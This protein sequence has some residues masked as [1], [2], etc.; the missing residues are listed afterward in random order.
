MIKFR[1]TA[2]RNWSTTNTLRTS[3][4][5]MN[6]M[7]RD[8]ASQHNWYRGGMR[9]INLPSILWILSK[10][11]FENVVKC[12]SITFAIYYLLNQYETLGPHSNAITAFVQT[13][14]I[15][16][17]LEQFNLTDI[18]RYIPILSLVH[19]QSVRNKI[20]NVKRS[21]YVWFQS[22]VIDLRSFWLNKFVP[23]G[24][25]CILLFAKF[26]TSVDAS[27]RL[28]RFHE[29]KRLAICI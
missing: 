19:V 27:K 20:A 28:K 8:E 26:L 4:H 21:I 18:C 11:V 1:S 2:E 14:I 17:D 16:N 7:N 29:R 15:I 25:E 22:L 5:N 23:I 6:E 13:I 24:F 12:V 3:R 10:G 9:D